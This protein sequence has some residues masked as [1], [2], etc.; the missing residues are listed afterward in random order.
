[1]KT[2]VTLNVLVSPNMFSLGLA[3][4]REVTNRPLY[5][6]AKVGGE[7]TVFPSAIFR[8]MG[9]RPDSCW[10]SAVGVLGAPSGGISVPQAKP[11]H[12]LL[13]GPPSTPCRTL[14]QTHHHLHPPCWLV[15]R[16]VCTASPFLIWAQRPW[17]EHESEGGRRSRRG[18]GRE[19]RG[20]IPWCFH[21]E[22][23]HNAYPCEQRWHRQ[24]QQRPPEGLPERLRAI[25]G[26]VKRGRE[27]LDA[28]SCCLGPGSTLPSVSQ[29]EREKK[30][31]RAWANWSS[32]SR[33]GCIKERERW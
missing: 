6:D 22:P 29:Q 8:P 30:A 33:T 18:R 19:V 24:R 27:Q 2:T 1:M 26:E 16:W 28:Y 17:L 13:P 9:S 10:S 23:L 5:N 32:S 25:W 21:G 14:I 4:L 7:K 31:G 15:G 11:W 3:V 12:P 20:C